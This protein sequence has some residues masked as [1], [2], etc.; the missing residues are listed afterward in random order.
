MLYLG[1]FLVILNALMLV[2]NL[3]P[4]TLFF[5]IPINLC[6]IAFSYYCVK[7]GKARRAPKITQQEM[8][9]RLREMAE[10]K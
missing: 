10:Y 9:D 4:P 7:V 2:W 5:V 6:A 1:W 3:F 8:E